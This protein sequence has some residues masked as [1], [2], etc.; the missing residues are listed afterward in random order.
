[1]NVEQTLKKAFYATDFT[2]NFTE[3]KMQ[4]HTLHATLEE[5]NIVLDIF[6]NFVLFLAL[7]HYRI[8]LCIL[9]FLHKFL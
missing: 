5:C 9:D 4:G 3:I 2:N 8:I 7:H 1:M 6:L